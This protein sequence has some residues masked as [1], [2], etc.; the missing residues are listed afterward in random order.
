MQ[1]WL[2]G[3]VAAEMQRT[4]SAGLHVDGYND[5][6]MHH[7][8]A[9]LDTTF[10]L[11]RPQG[12]SYVI[13]IS[14]CRWSPPTTVEVNGYADDTIT[15]E[16]CVLRQIDYQVTALVTIS[17][18]LS[19]EV[20]ANARNVS[21]DGLKLERQWV[22]VPYFSMLCMIGSELCNSKRRPL[23]TSPLDGGA[24][25]CFVV[26]GQLKHLV[27][28]T[29]LRKNVTVARVSARQLDR[30]TKVTWEFR[31][32][33]P[34]RHRATST[35]RGDVDVK[36]G[37]T[38][39]LPFYDTPLSVADV[40][41][42]INDACTVDDIRA[43]LLP[44]GDEEPVAWRNFVDDQAIAQVTDVAELRTLVSQANPRLDVIRLFDTEVLPHC[45]TVEQKLA[46]LGII[47][48]HAALVFLNVIPEASRDSA[49]Y[50]RVSL[51]TTIL[52]EF[53]RSV[54]NSLYLPKLTRMFQAK[55][56]AGVNIVDELPRHVP[57][58]NALTS[59]VRSA[60]LTGRFT[61]QVGGDDPISRSNLMQTAQTMNASALMGHQAKTL[62]PVNR[63]GKDVKAR[64]QGGD[65]WHVFDVADSTEGATCG[66]L[67]TRSGLSRVRRLETTAGQTELLVTHTLGHM[68]EQTGTWVVLDG[69][70]LCRT[71]T[72]DRFCATVRK[73]RRRGQL[74]YDIG[75][76]WVFVTPSNPRGEI[77]IQ[78]DAGEVL[79]P[80]FVAAKLPDLLE[81][82]KAHHALPPH[83]AWDEMVANGLIEY[84]GI[85]EALCDRHVVAESWRLANP[86]AHMWAEIEPSL[87]LLGT[88]TV[89]TVAAD[90]N[91][92]PRNSYHA[93]MKKQAHGPY[94]GRVSHE[95]LQYSLWYP[96]V[97]Q[98][99]LPAP[100][101]GNNPVV[102]IGVHNN[103][104]HVQI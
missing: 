35:L 92:G 16:D 55:L 24:A 52:C 101:N 39:K 26:A 89:F 98:V 13:R 14:D 84:V 8:P 18:F 104:V 74:P 2:D 44:H 68:F 45:S 34:K 103:A 59:K 46:C 29:H 73:L 66:L 19:D 86:A 10:V 27:L 64:Q 21:T 62:K 65:H 91:Q 5:A 51:P 61:L 70:P 38:V 31:S 94:V 6:M 43:A 3:V 11:T 9:L 87:S 100:Q 33:H 78:Y 82:N 47:V 79:S 56:A 36:S 67:N 17:A 81:F 42:L 96:Q 88:S 75:V 20:L 102:F 25:G 1:K 50:T 37:I 4:V 93:N 54:N 90:R 30:I 77:R 85:E 60:L 57:S 97:S 32:D 12:G 49:V 95:T 15:P 72:P 58:N 80:L 76:A 69:K 40:M 22:G 71:Q 7:I 83:T 99:F 41:L 23:S 28:P 53:I 48:R 63:E